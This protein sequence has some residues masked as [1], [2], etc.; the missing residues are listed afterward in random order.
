MP[1]RTLALLPAAAL[2]LG[3]AACSFEIGDVEPSE[4]PTSAESSAADQQPSQEESSAPPTD[5]AQSLAIE[6]SRLAEASEDALEAQLGYR[7]EIDCGDVNITIYLDR[8]TY[9]DLIDPVDG[10]EYEV[11]I[12]VTNIEGEQFE[13]DIAVDDVPQG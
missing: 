13:F 3:L 8:M 4:E 7:P 5:G 12:T 9:C 2:L 1:R 11:T 6:A 10:A